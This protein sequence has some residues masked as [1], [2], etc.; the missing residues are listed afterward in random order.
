MTDKTSDYLIDRLLKLDVPHGGRG[1]SKL[2][3]YAREEIKLYK[4]Q[5]GEE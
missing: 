4:K 3:Q 5:V 1:G 2:D